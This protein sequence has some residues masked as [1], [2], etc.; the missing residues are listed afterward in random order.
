MQLQV[1]LESGRKNGSGILSR[2]RLMMTIMSEGGGMRCFGDDSLWDAWIKWKLFPTFFS[3][4]ARCA[5]CV[6][7]GYKG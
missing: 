3:V 2:G 4:V 7:L 6:A 1:M 5:V